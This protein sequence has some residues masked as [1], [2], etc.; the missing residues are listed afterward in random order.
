MILIKPLGLFNSQIPAKVYLF[1]REILRLKKD[2][3]FTAFYF[4][5]YSQPNSHTLGKK[6]P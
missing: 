3:K 5:L 1:D 4:E 2:E 6:K